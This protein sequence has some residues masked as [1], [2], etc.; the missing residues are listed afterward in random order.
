MST[1]TLTVP[2]LV[3]G[4]RLSRDEFLRR[5]QGHPE[6]KKA[7]LIRGIVYLMSSPVSIDHGDMDSHVSTWLGVYAAATPGCATSN[8]A[9]TF[10]LEDC[11]Q[12]DGHLRL[13]PEAGGTSWVE[14]KYL[15]GVPELLAEVCLSS[16]AYDLHQKFDLFRE[17]GVKEYLAVL[18]YEQEIRWHY[19][20]R[21]TYQ[22]LA[23][24]AHGIF[25][26]RNFPGLWLNSKALVAD[27]M[28]KV[29][30]TLQKGIQ[31]EEHIRFVAR[32][33]KKM[34]SGS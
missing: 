5:W 27:D 26:S 28:A 8:N 15:H 22:L 18:L 29:L 21:K 14:N 9:T 10:L 20:S 32:L 25:R 17:A 12:P 1:V 31:S 11:P 13:L 6:I 16:T 19:L 23:P 4:D 2:Q 24:D 7:E 3:A 33:N 34:R 30:A